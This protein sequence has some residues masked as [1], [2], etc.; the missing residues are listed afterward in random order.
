MNVDQPLQ[1]SNEGEVGAGYIDLSTLTDEERRIAR[2]LATA[3]ETTTYEIRDKLSELM[4]G[5]YLS[6]GPVAQDLPLLRQHRITRVL[7]LA[8]ADV[9]TDAAFYSGDGIEF[10]AL[11]AVDAFDFD[12]MSLWPEAREFIDQGVV[13]TGTDDGWRRGQPKGRVLVHCHAGVN[14]SGAIALGY[15]M[16][17]R[18]VVMRMTGVKQ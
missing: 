5:L 8:P 14:R 1:G 13:G 18:Y 10:K 6:N 11:P 9:P 15:M 2:E 4:P 7:N 12:I 16:W 3:L 17:K